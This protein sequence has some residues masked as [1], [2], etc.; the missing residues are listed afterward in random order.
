LPKIRGKQKARSFDSASD[1]LIPSV[2]MPLKYHVLNLG[3]LTE[4]VY[5]YSFLSLAIFI[6]ISFSVS[7]GLKNKNSECSSAQ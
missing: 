4:N 7:G 2:L 1:F 6:A 5:G 3:L